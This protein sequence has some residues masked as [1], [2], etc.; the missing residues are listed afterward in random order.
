[1]SD[2]YKKKVNRIFSMLAIVI[3]FNY[4]CMASNNFQYY[5]LESGLKTVFALAVLSAFSVIVL[6]II[7][8]VGPGIYSCFKDFAKWLNGY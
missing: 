8:V 6:F 5:D 7:A 2:C 1:M 4:T 3:L